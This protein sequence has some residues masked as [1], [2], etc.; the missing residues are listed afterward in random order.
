MG[1]D[2]DV[3][4]ERV[5]LDELRVTAAELCLGLRMGLGEHVEAIPELEHL[6]LNNPVRESVTALLALALARASRQSQ[7]LDVLRGLSR[8]LRVE[9]GIDLSPML[10]NL[11]TG[12]LQQ[13][14]TYGLGR[15]MAE[16]ESV[17]V[18]TQGFVGRQE[19]RQRIDLALVAAAAGRGRTILV[20][21]E[22]GVGK[23]RLVDV[24]TEA[25]QGRGAK[26]VKVAIPHA[27]I[28]PELWAIHQLVTSA[29]PVS[30]SP[31]PNRM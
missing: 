9:M 24:M 10:Q 22:M 3:T 25:A 8:T 1:D 18:R 2:T 21:G 28:T 5:R 11:R 30:G 4:A 26:V 19:D 23:S 20:T 12:I 29:P 17:S 14:P 7:A 16:Q 15:S 31:F 13:D 27:S 6:A